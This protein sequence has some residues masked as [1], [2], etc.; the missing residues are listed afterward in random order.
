MDLGP[1]WQ[2]P[3]GLAGGKTVVEARGSRLAQTV[4][5]G[6]GGDSVWGLR[7]GGSCC[8]GLRVEG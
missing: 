7:G 6:E 2:L 5:A 3:P 4:V 8:P 1:G